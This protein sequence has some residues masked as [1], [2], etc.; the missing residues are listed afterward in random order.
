MARRAKSLLGAALITAFVVGATAP[1]AQAGWRCRGYRGGVFGPYVDPGCPSCGLRTASGPLH[2]EDL[3]R[4]GGS[5]PEISMLL[6][7]SRQVPTTS[8]T[9]PSSSAGLQ[10]QH[11]LQMAGSL[12]EIARR[13]NLS[14]QDL[15]GFL[16][17]APGPSEG[18][19]RVPPDQA[20]LKVWVPKGVKLTIDGYETRNLDARGIHLGSRKFVLRGLRPDKVHICT[21]SA[22][23]HYG[24]NEP[25]VTR[26]QD[27]EVQGGRSVECGFP[28]AE[29][30]AFREPPKPKPLS[31][32]KAE[33]AA[34]R[35]EAAATR[36]ETAAGNAQTATGNAQTA[37]SRAETA[38]GRA[39]T[40]ASNREVAVGE[41]AEKPSPEKP[42]PEKPSPEKP[43]PQK[44]SPEKPSPEKPSPEKPSPQKPS[45]E[46]PPP[47]KPSPEKPAPQEPSAE[48]RAPAEPAPWETTR[49]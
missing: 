14:Q 10:A 49:L 5:P 26:M 43:S 4:L 36:A 30:D 11:L 31:A 34:S 15:L 32:T 37:A 13:L 7:S 28:K 45:P 35:A 20:I 18:D 42:S 12:P 44:P 3:L 48:K 17:R 22:T 16:T 2:V 46:K 39:E 23:M 8:P 25:P 41:L 33:A 47:E 9:L 19:L 40:A 27:K 1:Q 6:D 29:F 21:I 24:P 38:A